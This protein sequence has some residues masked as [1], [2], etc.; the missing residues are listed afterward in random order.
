[1]TPNKVHVGRQLKDIAELADCLLESHDASRRTMVVPIIGAGASDSAGLPMF[2]ALKRDVYADIQS[3]RGFAQVA[4]DEAR[5]LFPKVGSDGALALLP[6]ECMAVLSRF[7]F[8]RDSISRVLG[9]RLQ[10]ATCR[11]LVYELLAHLTKHGFVDHFLS[12]NFD[13]LLDEALED[14]IP[15]R[16][17]LVASPDEVPGPRSA[18]ERPSTCYLMKPFGSLSKDNFK[19]EPKEVSSYGEESV[20]H[21]MMQRVFGGNNN[22]LTTILIVVGYAALEPAFEQLVEE[23]TKDPRRT[24]K[25]FVVDPAPS[26]PEVLTRLS[27]PKNFSVKHIQLP[28]DLAFEL[29]LQTL[30]LKYVNR[31][32]LGAWIPVA[33]HQII[34]ALPYE[35]TTFQ[36]RF[37]IEI[38][39][40][41][42]KSRGFFT[43]EGLAKI[44]RIRKYSQGAFGVLQQMRVEE[45]LEDKVPASSTGNFLRQNYALKLDHGP[46]AAKVLH[47]AS[48]NPEQLVASWL[49]SPAGD[50]FVVEK[51]QTTYGD[52]FEQR[53][54]EIASSPEI[55]VSS[56]ANPS[57]LWLF[58]NPI[59]LKSVADLTEATARLFERVLREAKG[60][61][62]LHGVW[63]TGEWLFHDEGWAWRS[64]GTNFID[65]LRKGTMDLSV[66][67]SKNPL[68][69]TD[70]LDRGEKVLQRLAEFKDRNNCT[71]HQLDWYRHNR[72]VTYLEWEGPRDKTERSGIY[73]RRRLATPLVEPVKV[74]GDD[75]RVLLD[76]FERYE[77]KVLFTPDGVYN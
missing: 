64:F 31:T 22:G 17:V 53:F 37:Q 54:K 3:S 42:V 26:P 46:L 66:V 55:E 52:L 25:V 18:T 69:Q 32:P 70:R 28:A 59:R 74:D 21:F 16:L 67:L 30:K 41:A 77:R 57:T 12:L 24:L 20:W 44:G 5:S 71:I 72:V 4:D 73:M 45:I 62:R 61:I 23:L 33:R 65:R 15:E 49:V 34:S 58:Q 40:Q 48:M 2:E 38:I 29:L 6:F 56:D 19:L 63:T 27:K 10:R 76:V 14:E 75:C 47:A 1:M 50:G 35:Y 7:A 68:G 8:G 11:P 43:I 39:L 51:T 60:T 9:S 13:E 36:K